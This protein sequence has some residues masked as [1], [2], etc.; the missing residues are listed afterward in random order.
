MDIHFL[1][2]LD[3][4]MMILL[5]PPGHQLQISP[6]LARPLPRHVPRTRR[7]CIPSLGR[8]I[9]L[10]AGSTMEIGLASVGVVVAVG[11]LPQQ[12]IVEVL[13]PVDNASGL[14]GDITKIQN[15]KTEKIQKQSKRKTKK[16]IFYFI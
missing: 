16:N 15:T 1:K 5:T 9:S 14:T 13:H 2:F 11:L 8:G 4:R 6:R 3:R 10:T 7:T 12:H